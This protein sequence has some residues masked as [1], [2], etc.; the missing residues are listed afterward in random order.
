MRRK[1]E[2]DWK[3]ERKERIKIRKSFNRIMK[4]EA[5]AKKKDLIKRERNSNK[6][7]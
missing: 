1:N 2:E 6:I 7:E 3:R 4:K 5:V